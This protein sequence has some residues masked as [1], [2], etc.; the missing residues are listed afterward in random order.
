MTKIDWKTEDDIRQAMK[1][2]ISDS[3]EAYEFGIRNPRQDPITAAIAAIKS[4]KWAK[5]FKNSVDL[6][7]KNI[8]RIS[9]EDWK[10]ATIN[11]SQQ[12]EDM[13]RGIGKENWKEYYVKAAPIISQASEKFIT[14]KKEESDYITFYTEMSKLHE[15]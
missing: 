3:K 15:I 10:K 13:C 11:S 9:L 8:A 4:G 14:S 7:A 5:N 2:G 12:Y 6:W 1:K